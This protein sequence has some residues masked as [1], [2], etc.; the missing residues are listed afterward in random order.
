MEYITTH[1]DVH[2][3]EAPTHAVVIST[4]DS[5]VFT[6]E[7]MDAPGAMVE[8]VETPAVATP[9]QAVRKKK[10]TPAYREQLLLQ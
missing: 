3:P 5:E 10:G 2:L 4:N 9:G 6:E 1:G 7:P 8:I